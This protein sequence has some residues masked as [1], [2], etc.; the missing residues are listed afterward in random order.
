MEKFQ[1][2]RNEALH[3]ITTLFQALQLSPFR[4]LDAKLHI[5][6]KTTKRELAQFSFRSRIEEIMLKLDA[7]K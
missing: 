1:P 3:V 2:R 5:A 7:M 6:S 4:T